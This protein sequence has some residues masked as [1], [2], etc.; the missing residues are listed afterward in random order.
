MPSAITLKPIFSAGLRPALSTVNTAIKVANMKVSPT[1]VVAII[2]CSV[3]VNPAILK[4]R[5]A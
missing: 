3:V 4:M 1:T 2:C 5:G